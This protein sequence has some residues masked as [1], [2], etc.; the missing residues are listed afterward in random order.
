MRRRLFHLLLALT[1]LVSFGV[2]AFASTLPDLTKKGSITFTMK[3]NKQD[4]DGGTLTIYRVGDIVQDD[5]N[6]S[7]HLIEKIDASKSVVEDPQKAG[8]AGELA[9]KVQRSDAYRDNVKIEKGQV[10]FTDVE[11]GLYLVM[12]HSAAAGYECISPFLIS[13]PQFTKG[14]YKLDV[15]ADP[16]VPIETKP[17]PT[18][19]PTTKP[20]QPGDKLPDTGQLN[21]PVPVLVCSGVALFVL[22]WVV[23]FGRKKECNEK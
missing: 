12:Q 20:T 8:L 14:E 22:G 9:S 17:A 6:Y 4:I 11:P 23:R 18:T 16:K 1:L 19:K 2:S 10:K 21:W 7:F 3:Y 13:V 5:A 15:T